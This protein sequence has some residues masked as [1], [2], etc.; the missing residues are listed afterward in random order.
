MEKKI[1][2][3]IALMFF[4]MIGVSLITAESGCFTYSD[5]PLYCN[6]IENSEAEVEC[7]FYE[8]CNL[9]TNFNAQQSCTEVTAF[10]ECEQI[11]CKSSCQYESRGGCASG[12]VP[13]E[14]E[15][16]WCSP[17]C[18]M[19][20]DASGDYC[21][22]E[23]T[24]WLCEN[25]ANNRNVN[26][27]GFETSWSEPECNSKCSGASGLPSSSSP[28]YS[29]SSSV[30]QSA[31]SP[32]EDSSV[33]TY[34]LQQSPSSSSAK[35]LTISVESSSG[36]WWWILGTLVLIALVYLAVRTYLRW[37]ELFSRASTGFI[38]EEKEPKTFDFQKTTQEAPIKVYVPKPSPKST[39][40]Q[41]KRIR[42]N[43]LIQAGL[44]P[45]PVKENPFRRLERVSQSHLA[46]K[47]AVKEVSVMERLKELISGK[48]RK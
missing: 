4:L 48:P 24:K 38:H 44:T 31:V 8:D 33:S 15:Q 3:G 20:S 46:K 37:E 13:E 18:C 41:K 6:D 9:Q 7:S 35:P 10:S 43:Y 16:Q 26:T 25:N 40:E 39:L 30:V 2:F 27:F 42:S 14:E 12:E 36:A 19:F 47:Q 28:S 21:S 29:S 22:Y 5:S 45:L 32:R 11:L 1:I 23:Q 34:S 17:G